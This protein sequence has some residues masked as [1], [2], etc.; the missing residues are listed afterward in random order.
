M[1]SPPCFRYT[2]R[3]HAQNSAKLH[4]IHPLHT[5]HRSLDFKQTLTW[6]DRGVSPP[7]SEPADRPHRLGPTFPHPPDV[8]QNQNHRKTLQRSRQSL[9]KPS[10]HRRPFVH[11]VDQSPHSPS[12]AISQVSPFRSP[13]PS[14]RFQFHLQPGAFRPLRLNP[15]LYLSRFCQV[16]L[17]PLEGQ[18]SNHGSF[19]PPGRPSFDAD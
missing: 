14:S 10:P 6:S 3:I 9:P 2:N 13:I 7:L 12:F 4:H 19:H 16:T 11:L 1:S 5:Y 17:P 8:Y 15:R 18:P